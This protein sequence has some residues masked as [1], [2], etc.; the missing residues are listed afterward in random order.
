MK[1]KTNVRVQIL[2]DLAF[3]EANKYNYTVYGDVNNCL[4]ERV[5]LAITLNRTRG[6]TGYTYIDTTPILCL[7]YMEKYGSFVV[8]SELHSKYGPGTGFALNPHV[9]GESIWDRYGFRSHGRLCGGENI[10]MYARSIS[11]TKDCVDMAYLTIAVVSDGYQSVEPDMVCDICGNTVYQSRHRDMGGECVICLEC[12]NRYASPN[13]YLSPWVT[14]FGFRNFFSAESIV[15]SGREYVVPWVASF[16]S[17]VYSR[18]PLSMM[19][20][21]IDVV[22]GAGHSGDYEDDEEEEEEDSDDDY[23][24]G[25]D[26]QDYDDNEDD[27]YE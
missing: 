21:T 23:D 15:V 27:S 7:C 20:N 13:L 5:M 19:E 6:V 4:N 9:I 18:C 24:E 25:N 3:L 8:E 14:R 1:I 10:A 16:D 26:E 17:E 11:T 2:G 12:V 22:F